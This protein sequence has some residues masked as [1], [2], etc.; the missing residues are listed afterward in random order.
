L[1]IQKLYNINNSKNLIPNSTT[2]VARFKI[3]FSS[4]SLISVPIEIS[5]A[6]LTSFST[7]SVKIS[8][9]SVFY[10][11]VLIPLNF[12]FNYKLFLK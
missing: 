7:S 1:F 10:V 8:D 9:K 11:F 4:V 2:Y 5:A 6:F 3:Y 12:I